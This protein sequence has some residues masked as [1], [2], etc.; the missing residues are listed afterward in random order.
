[1]EQ[2][3][4]ITTT[5]DVPDVLS[6]LVE[7]DAKPQIGDGWVTVLE[8]SRAREIRYNHDNTPQGISLALFDALMGFDIQ[9]GYHVLNV[10][11]LVVFILMCKALDDRERESVDAAFLHFNASWLS[12][13]SVVFGNDVVMVN[14]IER[15]AHSG[16]WMGFRCVAV[17]LPGV[18]G[19]GPDGFPSRVTFSRNGGEVPKDG[20]R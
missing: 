9:G 14:S 1:M 12:R 17:K 11:N 16:G 6:R 10:R 15:Y 13:G 7:L 3:A 2:Q 8:R 19:Y 4:V 20:P 18:V 5:Y